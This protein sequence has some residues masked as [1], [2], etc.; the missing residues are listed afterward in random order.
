MYV[1]RR[2]VLTGLGTLSL[3]VAHR[4]SKSAPSANLPKEVAGVAIPQTPLALGAATYARRNCPDFLFN[5]SARTFIFGALVLEKQ[6]KRAYLA[7]DAFVAAT[8]H[9]IGL[10]PSFET[11]KESFELDGANAVEQWLLKQGGSKAQAERAWYAVELHTGEWAL[12]L[13][14]G[15]EAMLI[16]LGASA[17]VD[18]PDPGDLDEKQI[19]DVLAAFPRLGF[20]HRFTDLLVRHCERKPLSQEGTWL[21]SMCRAHSAHPPPVDR[22]EKVIARAPF[23]E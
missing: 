17:D 2:E 1:R 8:F 15:P 4:W 10:L 11:P 7:E 20:K 14:Q 13:R 19:A 22:V 16:F 18:G 6:Q 9:D 21:E 23:S 3:L 12:P 5:H